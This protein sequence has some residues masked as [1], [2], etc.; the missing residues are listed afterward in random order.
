MLTVPPLQSPDILAR[1]FD[2]LVTG[3]CKRKVLEGPKSLAFRLSH[4]LEHMRN[5]SV[6][7]AQ[8]LPF[9]PICRRYDGVIETIDYALM[10]T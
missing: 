7:T 8:R 3:W 2:V 4:V 5:V 1:H 6:R 9:L 10:P